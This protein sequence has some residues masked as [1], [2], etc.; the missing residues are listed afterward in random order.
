MVHIGPVT[1][2]PVWPAGFVAAGAA[3]L[4][5]EVRVSRDSKKTPGI[6]RILISEIGEF[7]AIQRNIRTFIFNQGAKVRLFDNSKIS[8]APSNVK[9]I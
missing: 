4:E 8:A 7:S 3:F 9:I 6:I 5:H 2:K 1:I